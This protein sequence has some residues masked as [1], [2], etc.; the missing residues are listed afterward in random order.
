MILSLDVVISYLPEIP[1]NKIIIFGL[2]IV[3]VFALLESLVIF[4][5]LFPGQTIVVISGILVYLNYLPLVFTI[6]VASLGSIFGDAISYH[7]GKT[8]GNSFLKTYG[9][10]VLLPKQRLQELQKLISSHIGK[11]IFLG[12]F[13]NLTRSFIPFIA[14]SSNISTKQF[15]FW[16]ILTGIIWSLTSVFIGYFAGKSF[17]IIINYI[18]FGALILFLLIIGMWFLFKKKS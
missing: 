16:D 2:L 8:K 13:N 15:Y 17:E 7:L 5:T 9:K 10:Y 4:G 14:G 1:E 3:F 6:L 12:R 18:S 11:T